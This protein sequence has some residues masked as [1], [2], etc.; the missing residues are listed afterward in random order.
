MDSATAGVTGVV[1]FM[2]RVECLI[3]KHRVTAAYKIHSGEVGWGEYCCLCRL[4]GRRP[5]V[6]EMLLVIWGQYVLTLEHL[7]VTAVGGNEV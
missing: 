1:A 6:L 3:S 5:L 4:S 7:T 2:I